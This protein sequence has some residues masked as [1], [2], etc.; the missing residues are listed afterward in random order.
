MEIEENKLESSNEEELEEEKNEK[1]EIVE[2]KTQ[3]ST[4]EVK[5][6]EK[7][8]EESE[9]EDEDDEDEEPSGPGPV[10][11][12][13][14]K[15]F[16]HLDRGSSLT[17]EL[18]TG[19]FMFAIAISLLVMNMQILGAAANGTYEIGTSPKDAT[20]IAVAT[21]YFAI[22]QGSIIVS[23]ISCL[24]MG[25]L[26][27]L[28]FVHL[29]IMGLGTSLISLVGTTSGLTY[30]N[31]LFINFIASLIYAIVIG[32]PFI[33]RKLYEALP[34][35]IRKML[36]GATGLLLAF[37]A[38][39]ASGIFETKEISFGTSG[40]IST[41]QVSGLSSNLTGLGLSAFIAIII[42]FFIYLLLRSLRVKHALGLTFLVGFLGFIG[43]SVL[44]YGIDYTKD[45][46]FDNFGRIWLIAGS[47][48]EVDTPYADSYLTY[49]PKAFSQIFSNFGKVFTEGAN[50]SSY[51]GNTVLLIIS[52]I[53]TYVFM[54]LY[55]TESVVRGCAQD[56]EEKQE[57][58]DTIVDCTSD[59]ELAKVHY[60]TSGLNVV[61]PFLGV[62]Q[63]GVSVTSVCGTKNKA[64]SGLAPLV[65][66]ILM[67]VSLF[68]FVPAAFATETYQVTGGMSTWNYFAYGNGGIIYLIQGLKF[69][70]ADAIVGIVGISMLAGAI[71]DFDQKDFASV[72]TAA[73]LVVVTLLSTNLA[74]GVAVSMLFYVVDTLLSVKDSGEKLIPAFKNHFVE[75]F[76]KLPISTY[77]LAGVDLLY[78]ILML[79]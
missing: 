58:V 11:R 25:L 26:F 34:S 29:S 75:N 22:Y 6:G 68:V 54:G 27:R 71:K 47:S 66:A 41:L 28:P 36:P 20:N 38:L 67:I 62:G 33:R 44:Q 4:D 56:L 51:T 19:L 30:Y 45:G 77:C 21:E 9:E 59:K 10:S 64:K 14:N 16:H 23:I 76:K 5:D 69:G 52:S 74:F 55:H 32:V 13:L 40:G 42:A 15:F 50:F 31:L 3:E 79:C 17:K 7:Q 24:L 48:K 35:P 2:E 39:K 46:T 12:F 70:V 1:E 78:V 72:V 57:G 60:V 8:E 73:I 63:V 37:T 61:A 49:V 53:L 43:I 65:V 18:L